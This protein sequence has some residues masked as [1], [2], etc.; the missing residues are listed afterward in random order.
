MHDD[1]LTDRSSLADWLNY[2]GRVHPRSIEMGLERI[3][4][5][6]DTLGVLPLSPLDIV[7]AGTNG[8][9]STTVFASALLRARG[10]RVGTALSPHLVRFN[11]RIRIDGREVD[12]A[13]ICEAFERVE[14]ARGN[15]L[16][17][18]FEF[19]ILATFVIFRNARCDATVLEVGLG[20]RLDA[21]NL[22]DARVS[23]ITSI[24]IDHIEYLGPDRESIGA[25]KAGIL[26]AGTPLVYGETDMP[27]SVLTRAEAFDVPIY[28]QEQAFGAKMTAAGF[29]LWFTSNGGMTSFDGLP[30]PRLAL[31][32]VATATQAVALALERGLDRTTVL[33][34]I[35]SAALPGRFEDFVHLGR[36]VIIDVAHNPHGAAFLAKRLA[37]TRSRGRTL[38]IAG[39]L[40]DKDAPGIVAA[41]RDEIDDWT[42]VETRTERGQ[43]AQMCFD[44]V[45]TSLPLD[46]SVRARAMS[47]DEALASIDRVADE[48][49]RIV[50]FGSFDVVAR[51][52]DIVG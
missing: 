5:V 50:V 16:L 48:D 29:R 14:R 36:D 45:R 30:M 38:A 41:L 15:V 47:L 37:A 44:R 11:E 43:S 23:V 32:N 12:D 17:T 18:Y 4:R 33:K 51:T 35:D 42:F 39:F 34:A 25:E 52:R 27:T 24:G 21:V 2:I 7:V 26:R 49:D 13:T 20:G 8:K 28:R 46:E 40:K 3:R 9:G 6:A 31:D 1:E 10:L 19:S 22:V